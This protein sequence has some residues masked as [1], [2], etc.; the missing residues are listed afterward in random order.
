MEGQGNDE[1][2]QT[3]KERLR[4]VKSELKIELPI[5]WPREKAY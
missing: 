1:H 3:G 2:L 4:E 5:R